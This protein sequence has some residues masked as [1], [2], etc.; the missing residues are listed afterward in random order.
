MI[1]LLLALFF[2]LTFQVHAQVPETNTLYTYDCTA[3][4]NEASIKDFHLAQ[5]FK[6]GVIINQ[7]DRLTFERASDMDQKAYRYKGE[8]SSL[9]IKNIVLELSKSLT[10]GTGSGAAYLV[11]ANKRQEYSCSLDW[12]PY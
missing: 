2:T 4:S 10:K 8:I 1:K 9:P 5:E 11:N 12:S 7:Q 3:E 6:D